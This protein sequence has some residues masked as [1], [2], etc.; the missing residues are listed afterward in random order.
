MEGRAGAG[1]E[2]GFLEARFGGASRLPEAA[3]PVWEGP[4]PDEAQLEGLRVRDGLSAAPAVQVSV[5]RGYEA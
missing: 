3:E 5:L 4:I 1:D 2:A